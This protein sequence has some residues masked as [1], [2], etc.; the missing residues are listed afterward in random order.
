MGEV[1]AVGLNGGAGHLEYRRVGGGISEF[2]R[3][4]LG[5]RAAGL[6]DVRAC[7]RILGRQ[8]PE[9]GSGNEEVCLTSTTGTA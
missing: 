2:V 5:E 9:D 6:H 1:C 4:D 3:G 7:W 8:D